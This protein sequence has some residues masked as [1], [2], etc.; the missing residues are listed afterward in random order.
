MRQWR[1]LF[2][3]V[4]ITQYWEKKKLNFSGNR[5]PWYHSSGHVPSEH[6]PHNIVLHW[7]CK[8]VTF[9]F[10]DYKTHPLIGHCT[11]CWRCNRANR[12]SRR[13][14]RLHSKDIWLIEVDE[15]VCL[16]LRSLRCLHSAVRSRGCFGLS[17]SGRS[18][19]P[20]L[21]FR[22]QLYCCCRHILLHLLQFHRL[23]K[24]PSVSSRERRFG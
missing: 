9:S 6:M 3:C 18:H 7:K 13:H 24:R 23:K 1:V 4:K 22:P 16:Y 12:G 14:R 11:G 19:L 17:T 10:C 15:V 2:G 20:P 21:C 5:P 8:S